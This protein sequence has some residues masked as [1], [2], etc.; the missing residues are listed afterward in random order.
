[1][2]IALHSNYSLQTIFDIVGFV[3]G[4]VLGI[5]LMLLHKKKY[6]STFYLGVYLF[7]FSLEIAT[8]LSTNPEITETN[9]KLFLLPFNFAWLLFP[10]FFIYT[11]QVSILSD[12]KTKYWLL[13]PGIVSFIAQAI[14]FLLPTETKEVIGNSAWHKE[15][16]WMLGNYYSWCIGIWNLKLLYRHK[17]EVRNTYSYLE[18]RELRWA[19]NF[20]VFLLLT[21]IIGHLIAYVIPP[22]IFENKIIYSV[23]DY[24]AIFWVSYFGLVQ[25][26]IHT[27]VSK[28]ITYETEEDQPT[29]EQLHPVLNEE[30]LQEVKDKIDDYL[31]RTEDFTNP[32]LSIVDLA[33]DLKI[34][35]RRISTAINTLSEYNFSSY[36]NHYR[37]QKAKSLLLNDVNM[38]LTIEGIGKEAGFQSKSSFYSAFKKVTGTTRT[39]FKEKLVA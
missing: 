1:M 20:L 27:V 33:K 14:I 8:W 3:Q 5:L 2:N 25:R 13:Y 32:D 15:V 24:V 11:Q 26:N 7:L 21:S 12:E 17:I 19:R 4:T 34:H 35:P 39:K 30:L 31:I 36:I 22:S 18:F 28:N 38:N 23:F 9:P 16:F 37:I 6:R 29:E 10:L